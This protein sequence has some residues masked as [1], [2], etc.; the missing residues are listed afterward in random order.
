[1]ISEDETSRNKKSD[2]KWSVFPLE[3]YPQVRGAWQKLNQDGPDIPILDPDFYRLLT[4]YF[5]SGDELIAVCRHGDKTAAITILKRTR[6]LVWQTFQPAQGPLGAWLQDK[7]YS[8]ELLLAT[9]IRDL[10]E[11]CMLLGVS[12]LDPS[13]VPRKEFGKNIMAL[14]YIHTASVD[15]DSDFGQY[16]QARG[17]NLR[18][19]LKRQ[20]NRLKREDT[21][22][23]LSLVTSPDEA[24]D[25]VD[26]FG[27]LESRGW[28]GQAGTSLHPDNPQGRFYKALF[29][30]YCARSEGLIF[31]YSYGDKLVASDLCLHRNGVLM[32]LKT[33]YD[34]A[35]STSSPAML[36][37]QDAFEHI[38]D[39]GSFSR[40]EFY[41]RVM[42]W[43]LKWSSEVR[44]MYHLNCFRSPAVANIWRALSRL[45]RQTDV[46]SPT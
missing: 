17:R 8:I 5:G 32:I 6:K 21:V 10:P 11:L 27:V 25:A 28:K 13:I 46:S 35:Q 44:T 2:L 41:G 36:M 24:E 4:N 20:R 40:I 37:R 39:S 30:E 15:V 16:W 9:L 34:E 3:D 22:P 42:D 23:R 38:F 1:M 31:R 14:D 29:R 26:E 7:S 43:H 45:K 12:Q 33:A 19:N 18:Q